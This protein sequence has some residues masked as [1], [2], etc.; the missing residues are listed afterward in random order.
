[1]CVLIELGYNVEKTVHVFKLTDCIVYVYWY[2]VTKY[3][4]TP[5]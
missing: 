1:M 5:A 3:I 4:S 2:K